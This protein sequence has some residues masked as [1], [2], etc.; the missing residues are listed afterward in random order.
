MT[1]DDLFKINAGIVRDLVKGIAEFSPKAFILVISNPVNSTVPIAAEV[2]RNADVFDPKRLFGVTTLDVVRAETFVQALTGTKDPSKTT[3]PVIG[4]HSGE[5]IVPLFS[6]AKPAVDIP[7]DK[8]DALVNRVQFGGDEVVKA[9]NGAGSATLSMAYAGFRFAEKI[10]RAA[11]GEEGI[12]EPTY[13]YLPGVSGGE[14]IAKATGVDYFSVPVKL[15]PSGAEYA[16]N[17]LGLLNAY[18]KKLLEPCTAGLKGNI[19]KGIEFVRNPPP[20]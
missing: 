20:K 2:M 10:I 12:V 13:V 18:E 3:I 7:E 19:E 8:L 6:Q 11:K 15:G 14:E 5:T 16:N 4:G 9:K 17:P 1:R